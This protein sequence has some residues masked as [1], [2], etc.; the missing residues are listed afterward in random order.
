MS[1]LLLAFFVGW[2]LAGGGWRSLLRPDAGRQEAGVAAAAAPRAR[3]PKRPQKGRRPGS[4]G[5]RAG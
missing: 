4:V 5:S 1:W 3:R 2:L